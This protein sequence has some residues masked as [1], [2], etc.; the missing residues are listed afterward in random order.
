MSSNIKNITKHIADNLK[1]IFG[2]TEMLMEEV[3]ISTVIRNEL[4]LANKDWIKGYKS[5]LKEP[6]EKGGILKMI[7]ELK[8]I[9]SSK[10]VSSPREQF[11]L[12]SKQY[13]K[14]LQKC[15]YV[16]D[17]DCNFSSV[18]KED[19]QEILSIFP[20]IV[21][22]LT[23]E[24][25]E[26]NEWQEIII[27][28][29]KFDFNKYISEMYNDS[30]GKTI[31]VQRL[32]SLG[33]INVYSNVKKNYWSVRNYLVLQNALLTNLDILN[34]KGQQNPF[35]Y[36]NAFT[37]QEEMSLLNKEYMI[38][39]RQNIN[40]KIFN[41]LNLNNNSV[42]F[43]FIHLR[44][45]KENLPFVVD[46][47]EKK[48]HGNLFQTFMSHI[49]MGNDSDNLN[50]SLVHEISQYMNVD[51]EDCK[52]E[53]V[54]PYALE[55]ILFLLKKTKVIDLQRALDLENE[56]EKR[57]GGATL[58][59]R[60]VKISTSN[61]NI[62]VNKNIEKR[63]MEFI[64]K[65]FR[66]LNKEQK[67]KEYKW[68]LDN[69]TEKNQFDI[70]LMSLARD[71]ALT[72]V[73]DTN[74]EIEILVNL[75]LNNTKQYQHRC[76]INYVIWLNRYNPSMWGLS[77]ELSKSE[78]I[79]NVIPNN[80]ILEDNHKYINSNLQR[81]NSLL[82]KINTQEEQDKF[83]FL[84]E[85]VNKKLLGTSHIRSLLDSYKVCN[86][87]FKETI[88]LMNSGSIE[89]ELFREILLEKEL[90]TIIM[91]EFDL[92][93]NSVLNDSYLLKTNVPFKGLKPKLSDLDYD[94]FVNYEGSSTSF[95]IN[96]FLYAMSYQYI[97]EA[98]FAFEEDLNTF[99]NQQ[100][101]KHSFENIASDEILHFM[102]DWMY[103]VSREG[104]LKNKI[105]ENEQQ[106]KEEEEINEIILKQEKEKESSR[107]RKKI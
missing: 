35:I 28:Q 11:L 94:N 39:L 9:V 74:N 34:E 55:N 47:Y 8:N 77:D 73:G 92:K 27:N 60:I 44:L 89:N 66:Y 68:L 88:A 98:A 56:E 19:F 61:N 95:K 75:Y 91:K 49:H 96:H 93:I 76:D 1:D 3:S 101:D 59:S 43:G 2:S 97:G 41:I 69:N 22:C 31:K 58:F 4:F 85:Q 33:N 65:N 7:S 42:F 10:Q 102:K 6:D 25:V 50:L 16:I 23:K 90:Q 57:E 37:R 63:L 79:I 72:N 84:I 38:G 106:R 21:V 30:Y 71:N 18:S 82:S 29:L 12:F 20:E 80:K 40:Q 51:S 52:W 24:I 53:N 107:G 17:K 103:R 100:R 62:S 13:R 70:I 99:I 67:E 81:L 5:F 64:V 14:F 105:E 86:K 45:I 32:T 36:I 87:E 104:Y 26:K 48:L 15:L 46:M 54:S 78:N 83:F